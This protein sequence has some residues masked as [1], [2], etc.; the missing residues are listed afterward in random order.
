MLILNITNNMK[1]IILFILFNLNSYCQQKIDIG[2]EAR[3]ELNFKEYKNQK[4]E[5]LKNTFILVFNKNESFFKNMSVYVKDSLVDAGKIKVTGDVQKDFITLGK[6]VPDFPY[7]VYKNYN[8]ITF[9]NNI[10]FA[11]DFR[12][13]EKIDF[14]WKITKGTK[15][16]NGIKCVRALTTKWGRNWIAFYSPNHPLPFG[17]YKFNGLPGL[18]FEVSDE[19]KDYTFSLYRFKKRVKNNLL[20]HNYP[21]SISVTKVKY[22]K[23]RKEVALHPSFIDGEKDS[24]V[25]KDMIKFS[26]EKELNYN[27]I[28]LTD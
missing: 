10:P 11:G 3:Y 4:P 6:Y 12:Y 9:A 13:N 15:I 20:L 24:K 16:I 8:S 22:E 7:T 27:P 17:P 18:I 19:N 14:K 21:K 2:F 5:Y 25:K 1:K 23:I 28:E 26:K